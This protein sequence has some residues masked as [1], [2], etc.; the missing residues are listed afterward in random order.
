MTFRIGRCDVPT[1]GGNMSESLISDIV[2]SDRV[3]DSEKGFVFQ[4][5]L[6]CDY[7][8]KHRDGYYASHELGV[9]NHDR[10][11]PLL[12]TFLNEIHEYNQQHSKSYAKRLRE[13]S[14][15]WRNC[16]AI[17]SE[18][19]VYRSYVRGI[20]E[21]LIRKIEL[22]EAEADIDYRTAR[23]LE[24]VH[25]GILRDAQPPAARKGWVRDIRHQ[26]AY[27]D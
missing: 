11:Y 8:Q 9:L 22:D 13:A 2:S 19:I 17:F 21:Q 24:G 12:L 6:A 4:D 15:D 7:F 27:P 3:T 26:D 23:R 18:I 1:V 14:K 16:E 10:N 20:H 25:G 5:L